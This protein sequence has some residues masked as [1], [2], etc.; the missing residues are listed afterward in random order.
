MR[1]QKMLV[2]KTFYSSGGSCVAVER[3]YRRKFS[4][5]VLTSRDAIHQTAKQS[6]ETGI[7]CDKRAK[8]RKC[9]A[10]ART[11]GVIGVA[12][13]AVIRSPR[14]SVRRLAQHIDSIICQNR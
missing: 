3:Q 14:K 2:I 6:E 12:W 11:E 13:E 9:R 1:D 7:M 4:V 5:R 10:S 8:G